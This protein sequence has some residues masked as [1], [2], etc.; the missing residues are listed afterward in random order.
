V[1]QKRG[2]RKR[3]KRNELKGKTQSEDKSKVAAEDKAKVVAEVKVKTQSDNQNHWY[4]FP[5][6]V[7]ERTARGK[8]P[9]DF[10]MK[11]VYHKL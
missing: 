6:G 2:T 10:K 3:S 8:A 11:K 1:E 4:L 5:P 9:R 7:P